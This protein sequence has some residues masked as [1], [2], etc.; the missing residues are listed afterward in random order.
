MSTAANDN[1]CSRSGNTFSRLLKSFVARGRH[2]RVM[3][4]MMGLNDHMLR[5]I[6][7]TRFDVVRAV[8]GRNEGSRG[9]ALARIV[10]RN[11]LEQVRLEMAALEIRP[12]SAD[13]RVMLA[14]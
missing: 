12:H 5:D 7:V 13:E 10:E 4:E 9:D 1:A 8:H 3:R 6:G 14:A 11:R 2:R